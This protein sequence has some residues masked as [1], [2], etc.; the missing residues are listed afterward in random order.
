M[1]NLYNEDNAKVLKALGAHSKLSKF[2]GIF[3]NPNTF[4]IYFSKE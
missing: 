1:K 4:L 2:N 3:P